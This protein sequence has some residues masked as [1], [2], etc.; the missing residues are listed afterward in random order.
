MRSRLR[1]W[2]DVYVITSLVA[3]WVQVADQSDRVLAV[4]H[5][6]DPVYLTAAMVL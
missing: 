3:V 2:P 1:N 5:K 6:C 4:G